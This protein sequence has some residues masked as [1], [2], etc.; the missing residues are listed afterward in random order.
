MTKSQSA[1]FQEIFGAS[2]IAESL[3]ANTPVSYSNKPE[4]V[5][6]TDNELWELLTTSS[7]RVAQHIEDQEFIREISGAEPSA[8]LPVFT[9]KTESAGHEL[10]DF[11][12]RAARVLR[13]A[14]AHRR[15]MQKIVGRIR[16]SAMF[17][18]VRNDPAW[19]RLV[20][21]GVNFV[22]GAILEAGT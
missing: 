14:P 22:V 10:R 3:D 6:P 11:T 9:P 20:E 8:S 7:G 19:D 15:A 1:D 21:T 4:P 12:K 17:E 16:N 13:D 5:L 2:T 18:P